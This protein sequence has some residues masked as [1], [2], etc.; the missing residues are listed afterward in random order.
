[1]EADIDR[2]LDTAVALIPND[3]LIARLIGDVR[4]WHAAAA[5]RNGGR[6]SPGFADATATTVMAATATW[7]PTTP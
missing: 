2:L 1:M 6:P 4:D 7:C 3:S 5:A